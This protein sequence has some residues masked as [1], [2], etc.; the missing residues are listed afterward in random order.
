MR[1]V[2]PVLLTVA[3]P[4]PRHIPPS[5]KIHTDI[6]DNRKLPVSTGINKSYLNL[7]FNALLSCGSC[8][9]LFEEA[10]WHV[11]LRC[12][13]VPFILSFCFMSTFMGR[14][15]NK[16][17][18]KMF[19]YLTFHIQTRSV[20]DGSV[21]TGTTVSEIWR[22][23]K[24]VWRGKNQTIILVLRENKSKITTQTVCGEHPGTTLICR[25]CQSCACTHFSYVSRD[26][27]IYFQI[28]WFR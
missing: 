13:L 11:P 24:N 10:D 21:E 8:C 22:C 4:H 12:C 5:W 27:Y 3:R 15:T 28:K 20:L 17:Q 1:T 9:W 26:N 7:P 16:A 23:S 25:T 19:T 14:H 6:K 18:L 2:I